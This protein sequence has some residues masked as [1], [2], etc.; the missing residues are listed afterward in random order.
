MTNAKLYF[1]ERLIFDSCFL[2]LDLATFFGVFAA[3][4]NFSTQD[5][6][7]I[8]EITKKSKDFDFLN[9]LRI[10]LKKSSSQNTG[11]LLTYGASINYVD[12]LWGSRR[13]PKRQRSL[14]T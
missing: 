10:C 5:A 8:G 14:F 4:L 1:K 11:L 3:L 7:V 6:N 9:V 2:V 13:P 12:M